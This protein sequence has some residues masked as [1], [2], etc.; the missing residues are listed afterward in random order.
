MTSPARISATPNLPPGALEALLDST[1]DGTYTGRLMQATIILAVDTGMRPQEL[2]AVRCQNLNRETRCLRIP[3][4]D[5]KTAGG[6]VSYGQTTAEALTDYLD[7]RAGRPGAGQTDRL[8]LNS[9]GQPLAYRHWHRLLKRYAAQAGFPEVCPYAFRVFFATA[10]FR[11]GTDPETVRKA[12]RHRDPTMTR[13]YQRV[14][15][16][17]RAASDLF[18]HNLM[19]HMTRQ[20]PVSN[21]AS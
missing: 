6:L 4:A 16:D 3:E 21:E 14:S 11:L 9:R 10:H 17:E 8:F 19:D 7:A 20:G 15:D 5:A 1:R 12:L 13:H 18:T 2:C